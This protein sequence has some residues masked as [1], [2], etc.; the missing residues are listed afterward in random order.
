MNSAIAR[1]AADVADLGSNR[2]A[3]DP[4]DPR[5]A[6]QQRQVAVL[7][8][9]AAELALDLVDLPLEHVDQVETRLDG[10]APW[11]GQLTALEE[12]PSAGAEEVGDRRAQGRAGRGSHG[13]GS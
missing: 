3:Q 5:H 11:L 10:R 12:A 1:E 8:A 2:V 9:E 13:C 4:A 6:Q 7:G